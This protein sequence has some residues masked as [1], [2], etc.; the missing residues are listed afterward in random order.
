MN[1]ESAILTV[2][3]LV[4][5]VNVAA[6]GDITGT[7]T[8]KGTPPKEKDITPLKE[9]V[10]CGKLH[11]EMPT[12]HFYVVGPGGELADAVVTLQG[13]SGKSTGAQADPAVLDQRGCEYVPSIMAIQT[14]QKLLVKNSDPV[15]HNVHTRP[16]VQ[17]NDEKNNAQMPSGPDLTF[18]FAK[19][20]MFLK[21]QCDVHPWMFAWISVIDHPYFAVS[22]KDGKYTIKNVPDGK[23]TLAV[24]HRKAA[25]AANPVTAEIEVKGGNVTKDFTLE[26]K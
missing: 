10:N 17:G 15:M 13:I 21:F 20:E 16:T 12:T 22:G 1:K 11:T 14:G 3:G 18:A 9:D 19:P 8:L 2:V 26:P 4:V 7:I 5:A 23:Y 6:A 24:Y 25:P